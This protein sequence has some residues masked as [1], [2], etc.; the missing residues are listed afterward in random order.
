[1]HIMSDAHWDDLKTVMHLVRGQSLVAA[2]E[3][4]GVNYTTVARRIARVEK[5]LGMTLFERLA[6]GYRPT[7][8]GQIVARKAAEMEQRE[9]DLLRAL[10]QHDQTLKG[11][12]TVTA[13][14]LL[15]STILP[16]VFETFCTRY[17]E[18]DL[19]IRAGTDLL[20]L[21]R[22]EADLAIRISNSPGDDLVGLCLSS[23]DQACFGTPEWAQRIGADPRGLIEWIVYKTPGKVPKASLQNYPNARVKLVVDDM[24]A[25][26]GAVQAG[27]G[28]GRMPMFIGRSYPGLVQLPVLPVG[29]Y[30]DIW[31]VAHR[32]VWPSKR[33]KAFRDCL[34]PHFKAKSALFVG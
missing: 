3:A 17:P 27:L 22:R 32:D 9:F 23:Q 6:D 29:R 15:C 33:V 21:D 28:V 25:L 1:M 12:L 31:A 4:L 16:E 8:A 7:E 11:R 2:A 26:I 19:N 20:D 5:A 34:V 13:P 10:G 24:I 18:V 30:T 14:Q